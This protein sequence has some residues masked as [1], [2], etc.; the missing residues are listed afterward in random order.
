MAQTRK[1]T[2]VTDEDGDGTDVVLADK[3]E[4]IS[5]NF[6]KRADAWIF[7]EELDRLLSAY[8]DDLIDLQKVG[9]NLVDSRLQ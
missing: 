3:D 1:I 5:W 8:T 7:A 4:G 6:K 9:F 2:V